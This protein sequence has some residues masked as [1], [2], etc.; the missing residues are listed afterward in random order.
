MKN[1][2][3]TEQLINQK[4]NVEKIAS[5]DFYLSMLYRTLQDACDEKDRIL[6][7][8]SGAGTSKKYLNSKHI[9]RTDLIVCEEPGIHGN[10][11]AQ[12][13][14][15]KDAT[16]DLIIGMDFIHHIQRPSL[17][18]RE[19]K[20]VLN[21]DSEG[22]QMVF[23]E[24]YVSVVSYLPFKLLHKEQTSLLK[25]RKL[26]EPLVGKMAED[27]DQTIPRLLFCSKKGR[28]LVEE[29][30]P[31]EIYEVLIS[32]VSIWS[33]FITGGINHPLPTP[34]WLVKFFLQIESKMP[35]KIMKLASS[36]MVIK[37]QKREQQSLRN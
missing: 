20:R 12:A 32:Y 11:D 19:M 24:P 2:N 36:R 27:G 18:F 7:L 9:Y 33:F 17:A 8:G 21:D 25:K 34:V 6:E 10:V 16:F 4:K 5:I 13:L 23:I 31:K 15:F 14:P 35:K 28:S 26:A 1:R 29:V 30:F 37:I 3:Y 22:I